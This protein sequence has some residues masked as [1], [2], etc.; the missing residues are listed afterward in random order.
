MDVHHAPGDISCYPEDSHDE[1]EGGAD[2][3]EDNSRGATLCLGSFDV[4]ELL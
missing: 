2:V 4:V 3:R 1:K